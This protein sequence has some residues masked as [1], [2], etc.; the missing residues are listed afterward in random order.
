VLRNFVIATFSDADKLLKAVRKVRDHHLSVYDVYAPYPIHG[1]DEAMGLRRSR[2]PWVTL[3]VGFFGLM[4]A[5][6]FQFYTNV[7]DW[8]LNVGG[9]PDNSTLAFVPICF[10]L[11][12]LLGGL[13]TFAALLVRASLYPGKREQL[14]IEGVTN[15]TFALVLRK[16]DAAFDVRSVCEL[17]DQSGAEGVEVREAKL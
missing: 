9:K 1:L 3:I 12:V 13:A 16:K 8:P 7:F 15:D 17:L 5:L 4:T 2:I 14:P 11:T 10:E 6:V